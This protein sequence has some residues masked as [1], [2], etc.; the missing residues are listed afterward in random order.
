MWNNIVQGTYFGTRVYT[1][2][3]INIIIISHGDFNGGALQWWIAFKNVLIH[4]YIILDVKMTFENS[5]YTPEHTYVYTNSISWQWFYIFYRTLR[6]PIRPLQSPP[7]LGYGILLYYMYNT[8]R[9]LHI[10]FL[11]NTISHVMIIIIIIIRFREPTRVYITRLY[12]LCTRISAR[13]RSYRRVSPTSY[14]YNIHIPSQL[15]F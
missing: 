4:Y 5:T 10:F 6:F 7:L 12:L 1:V 3:T 2:N 11:C 9:L 13:S 14:K 15:P 8:S